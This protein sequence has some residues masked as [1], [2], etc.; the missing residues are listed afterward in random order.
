MLISTKGIKVLDSDA[1]FRRY[2][3]SRV[4]FYHD[5]TR[6]DLLTLHNANQKIAFTN[7]DIDPALIDDWDK[8]E[9]TDYAFDV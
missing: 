7:G 3:N 8:L 1:I 9:R 5:H 4:G 6:P 2:V